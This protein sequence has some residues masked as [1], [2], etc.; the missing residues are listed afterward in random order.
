MFINSLLF[1]ISLS[2][3]CYLCHVT[4]E[5]GLRVHLIKDVIF[6]MQHDTIVVYTCYM[7]FSIPCI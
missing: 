1:S 5:K 4:A 3:Q 7:V 6:S 2:H